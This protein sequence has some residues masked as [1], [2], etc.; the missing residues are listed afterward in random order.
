MRGAPSTELIRRRTAL[1]QGHQIA[2]VCSARSS[3]TKGAGTTSLLLRAATEALAAGHANGIA[4]L[5]ATSSPSMSPVLRSP[6]PETT[7]FG[8]SSGING[9]YSDS[10]SFG[11]SPI[12]SPR[13]GFRFGPQPIAQSF[14]LVN[15]AA[16]TFHALIDQ[17]QEEHMAAARHLIRDSDILGVFQV[18]LEVGD[19]TA[20]RS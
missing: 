9:S 11:G 13:S 16:P 7:Y 15:G 1:D 4:S 18:S 2:I 14:G 12:A 17:I 10:P 20:V 8:L 5:S 6:A 19:A 3:S